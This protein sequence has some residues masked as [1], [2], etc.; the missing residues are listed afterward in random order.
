MAGLFSTFNV[1]KSGMSAQQQVINTTS[2]NISNAATEG[3][4]RQRAVLKTNAPQTTTG[5]VAG[6]IGTGVQVAAIERIRDTFLDYQVRNENSIYEQYTTREKFLSEIEGI[7]NEPS[8]S[9]LSTQ[10][11]TFFDA[12]QE[13]SKQ[14]QSSNARTVVAQQALALTDLI[15]SS[16]NKLQNLRN[17]AQDLMLSSVKNI[18]SILSELDDY[19]R[20]I[21]S[22]TAS[23]NTPNDLMDKRDMLLDELSGKFNITVE[24]GLYNGVTVKP[25]DTNGMVTPEL[26]QADLTSTQARF[27]YVSG[28]EQDPSDPSG[29]TYKITYYKC[30][31][32]D[33]EQSKQTLTVTGLT[34]DKLNDLKT[35][36]ILW[37]DLDGTATRADGFPIRNGD[38]I[39]AS[40]LMIFKPTTGEVAGNSSIQ[41]DIDTYIDGIN[42]IAKTLAFAV[43]SIH[44]GMQ[45]PIDEKG[46]PGYD[47]MPFFVNADVAI[48]DKNMNMTNIYDILNSESGINGGNLTVN[49]EIIAD[50]MKIKTRTTDFNYLTADQNTVDGEGDG[51]RA[52]AIAKL[53]NTLILVQDVGINITNR[54]ELFTRGGSTFS[55]SYMTIENNI[56]GMT[57]DSYFKNMTNTLG[58]QSKKAQDMVASQKNVL[59]ALNQ[60]RDSESGVSLDEEMANLIQYQH[61]Y[62]ANAKVI[63]TVDE[64]LDVVVNGLKR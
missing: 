21:V 53:R 54:N 3:Y 1:A 37:A 27:S 31:Q 17:N 10:L 19:N 61:S 41:A 28:I 35:N 6:Q 39:P 40:E 22:V 59:D 58:V 47:G 5:G 24:K 43:N 62:T 12:W 7:F 63:S 13:L 20:Q 46:T 32:T 60:R 23:G 52:L 4:S 34:P 56:S 42:K 16:Y 25:V 29:N 45:N 38:T 55:N 33:N 2:H 14:P 36:R 26:I 51:S 48:Y 11:G 15:N 64:L 8:D 57:L 30:G 44:S 9:G 49:K 18:N 50:V